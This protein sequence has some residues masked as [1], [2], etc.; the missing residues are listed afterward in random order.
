[1]KNLMGGMDK[2]TKLQ[3]CIDHLTDNTSENSP[4]E[5]DIIISVGTQVCWDNYERMTS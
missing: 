3:Y 1:M 4:E 5:V 2:E